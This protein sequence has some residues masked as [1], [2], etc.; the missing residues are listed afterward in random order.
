MDKFVAT[1][2]FIVFCVFVFV[3]LFE[4]D[5]NDALDSKTKA[6]IEVIEGTNLQ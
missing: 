1:L 2:L 3:T 5:V 6:A 4:G